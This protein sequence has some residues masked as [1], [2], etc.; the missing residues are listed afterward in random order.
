MMNKKN[1]DNAYLNT[2]D[3]LKTISRE[4]YML[5]QTINQ[6]S[7][8]AINSSVDDGFLKYSSSRIN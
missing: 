5:Q 3:N 4:R 1:E 6:Q 7:N 2:F 8:K